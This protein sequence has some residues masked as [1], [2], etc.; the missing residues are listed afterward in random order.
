M[1]EALILQALDSPSRKVS[2]M[3]AQCTERIYP[4]ADPQP[5]GWRVVGTILRFT[6]RG[7]PAFS[8]SF[9]HG[10]REQSFMELLF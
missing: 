2:V 8:A 4:Q 5:P 6:G 10:C 1:M 9:D 3:G 7:N